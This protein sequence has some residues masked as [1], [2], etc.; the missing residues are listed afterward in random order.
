MVEATSNLAPTAWPLKPA[1]I[2]LGKGP[3]Q[4]LILADHTVRARA[5]LSYLA[6][7]Y[8]IPMAG[9]VGAP[10]AE[11]APEGS[12]GTAGLDVPPA[13]APAAEP[14]S[15]EDPWP[16]RYCRNE[17]ANSYAKNAAESRIPDKGSRLAAE[18]IG[19]SSPK[20]RAA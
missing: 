3:R 18:R 15:K 20:R 11:R 7:L 5:A 6:P 1:Y 12:G 4:F 2:R 13:T 17:A 8:R 14:H 16:Q 9:R 19:A 10:I